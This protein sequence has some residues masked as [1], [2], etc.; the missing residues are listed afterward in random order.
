MSTQAISTSSLICIGRSRRSEMMRVAGTRNATEFHERMH[1]TLPAEPE[2][3]LAKGQL[4]PLPNRNLTLH[5]LEGEIW[6][7]RYGDREDYILGPGQTLAV[8]RG[9]QAAI[10]AL[11]DCRFRL[12]HA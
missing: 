3:A 10:Q 4:R 12:G 1:A 5:C 9:D 8:R 11:R 2:Q 6:L 7:T